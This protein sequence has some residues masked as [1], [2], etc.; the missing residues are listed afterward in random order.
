MVPILARQGRNYCLLIVIVGYEKRVY[1]H[2]LTGV[3]KLKLPSTMTV[4]PP[5]HDVWRVSI[6]TIPSSIASSPAICERAGGGS[7]LGELK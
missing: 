7:R 3:S 6:P 4:G 2:G 5:V 1:E